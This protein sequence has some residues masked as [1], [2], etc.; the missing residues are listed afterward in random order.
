M[1]VKTRYLLTD[2]TDYKIIKSL[3]ISDIRIIRN[4]FTSNIIIKVRLANLNQVKLQL[5]KQKI[6]VLKISGTLKSLKNQNN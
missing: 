3:D 2:V 4:D 6:K 1:K 5:T